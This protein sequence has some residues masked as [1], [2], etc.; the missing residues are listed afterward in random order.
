MRLSGERLG[1]GGDDEKRPMAGLPPVE[2]HC[3]WRAAHATA[4]YSERR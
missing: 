3:Y 4:P 1:F 2:M